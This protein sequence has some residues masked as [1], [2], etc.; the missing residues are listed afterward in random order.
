MSLELREKCD[1]ID[2]EKNVNFKPEIVYHLVS[3]QGLN[4]ALRHK[5]SI[6]YNQAGTFAVLEF[7]IEKG[8]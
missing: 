4:K 1:T 5:Y 2:I 3:I 7:V 8:L 6:K